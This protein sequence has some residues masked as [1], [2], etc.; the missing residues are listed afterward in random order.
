VLMGKPVAFVRV[1]ETG[2]PRAV[3]FPEASRLTDFPAG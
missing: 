2:V 3:A 1:A